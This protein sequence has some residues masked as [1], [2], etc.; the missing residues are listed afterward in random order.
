MTKVVSRLDARIPYGLYREALEDP[1]QLEDDV[2]ND[3]DDDSDLERDDVSL[4]D[5]NAEEEEA[6]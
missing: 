5:G 3:E 1:Q 4:V 2:G 6:D